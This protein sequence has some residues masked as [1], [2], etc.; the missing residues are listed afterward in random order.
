MKNFKTLLL[1]AV[2]TLGVAGVANAQKIGH[3]DY[4]R[5]IDNM[6]ETRA[7]S[8]TLEKLGKSYQN[9]IEGLKKKLEAKVQKYTAEQATQT[10][11]T[12]KQRAQEV[13]V[14]KAR[15]DQAQQA[16]YQEMQKKQADGLKPIVEKAEKAIESAAASKGIL[17][18]LDA[19]SLIVKKGEDLYS[20]VKAKL[21][22]LKDLP[23]PQQ[24]RQ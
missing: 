3:V 11:A 17:Y 15:F 12:N 7:L 10:E 2:F 6:P 1:I 18:V 21:G 22:L 8:T 20:A 23:K 19:K 4:Q 16:A 5:V 24:V 9:E 14:D 13:Q